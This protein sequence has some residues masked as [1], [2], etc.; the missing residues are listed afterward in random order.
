MRLL[1]VIKAMKGRKV[2]VVGDLILDRFIWGSVDRISPEAPVPVVEVHS[3]STMLGGAGNVASNLAALGGRAT[4]LGAMGEDIAA[5]RM[6]E[7]LSE[8]GIERIDVRDDRPTTQ[9][10]RV[11]AHGQ[12]VVRFD[13]E[14]NAPL[15]GRALKTM[16]DVIRSEARDYDAIIISDY[17]KGVVSKKLISA[18]TSTVRKGT[19][20][21]LD[22]KVGNFH[23]YREVSV[24]TPNLKEAAA[25]S[26][27]EITGPESLKQAA[28]ALMSKLSLS[29][30]LITRGGKGM[31][32]FEG[33]KVSH[34]PAIPKKV[35]D[36]T[37]AGDTVIAA[38]AL[39]RAAGATGGEAAVIANHAAGY[40]VGEVG[41]AVAASEAVKDSIR[42]S[43]IEI[44]EERLR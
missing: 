7:L 14:D 21:A 6:H 43:D 39:A 24:I 20:V 36:V 31:S 4:V 35:F 30:V 15:G 1:S 25:G 9:K 3:E 29:S 38:Y 44:S 26:G 33:R 2:L 37:G 10:T 16:L 32:L 12:H 42:S 40:V 28:A 19:P 22:P 18:V 41:T 17:R 34:I 13:Q 11:I 5:E 27:V 8:H 23:L